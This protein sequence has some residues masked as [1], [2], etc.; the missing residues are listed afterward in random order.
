MP[1]TS[2]N[3][4]P[5]SPLIIQNYVAL[6][7]IEPDAQRSHDQKDQEQANHPQSERKKFVRALFGF[8]GD[9][10]I[11]PEQKSRDNAHHNAGNDHQPDK[12][13]QVASAGPEEIF[14]RQ[15]IGR[16][17]SRKN[18]WQEQRGGEKEQAGKPKSRGGHRDHRTK[19]RTRQ[20][21]DQG[22]QMK[23]I[24]QAVAVQTVI[25]DGVRA[26]LDDLAA[27]FERLLARRILGFQ[28]THD[29]L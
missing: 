19:L 3:G 23:S 2:N 22:S 1:E 11:G 13:P 17:I 29:L 20:Q 6:G 7:Q 27:Q 25:E 8:S 4:S 10:S 14:S 18:S 5:H 16:T 28:R 24:D 15:T 26:V 12:A 9:G 21:V